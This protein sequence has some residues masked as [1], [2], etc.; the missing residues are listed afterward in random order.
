MTTPQSLTYLKKNFK[1]N[2]ENKVANHANPRHAPPTKREARLATRLLDWE[3]NGSRKNNLPA[4]SYHRPG[5]L[6]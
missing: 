3:R 5:S 1:G 6:Q 4:V 2:K